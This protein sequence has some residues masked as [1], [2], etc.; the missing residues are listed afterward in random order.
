MHIMLHSFLVLTPCVQVHG[1]PSLF[2]KIKFIFFG[3]RRTLNSGVQI[4]LINWG[5]WIMGLGSFHIEVHFLDCLE[6]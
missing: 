1:S 4:L 2:L 6:R 5:S 3:K